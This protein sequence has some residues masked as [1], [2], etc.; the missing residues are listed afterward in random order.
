VGAL[1]YQDEAGV[2]QR[3]PDIGRPTVPPLVELRAL[4]AASQKM[5][6]NRE[7]MADL[8]FL[9][10]R[11]TS[12]GGMRPKGTVVDADGCLAIGK[13]P[14]QNDERAVTK[15]EVLALTLAKSAGLTAAEARLVVIDRQAVAVIRRFD[16]L[17]GDQRIHFI[18][19]ATL[20]GVPRGDPG[21]HSYAEIVDAIRRHG[22][23]VQEDVEEL[24]RRMVFPC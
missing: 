13:F 24:W 21:D 22:A 15:G 10:G 18:S 11:G 16:R 1:R 8:A 5:E 9:L 3:A 20:L 19:A 17:G 23:A 2:F 7:T 6:A 4:L 14:S 12:L